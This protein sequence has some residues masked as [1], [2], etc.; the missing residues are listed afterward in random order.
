MALTP[1]ETLPGNNS[2]VFPMKIAQSALIESTFSSTGAVTEDATIALGWKPTDSVTAPLCDETGHYLLTIRK[3]GDAITIWK[4]GAQIAT[5]SY[6][7]VGGATYAQLLQNVLTAIAGSHYGYYSRVVVIEQALDY[8]VF[9]EQSELVTG[10]W[11]PK[12]LGALAPHTLLTFGDSA[13]LGQ[14]GSGNGN[15]WTITGTQ[16]TDTPTNNHATLNPMVG[17]PSTHT[18]YNAPGFSGGNT[19]A[20]ASG[21]GTYNCCLSSMPLPDTGKW[22]W[23]WEIISF[24]DSVVLTLVQHLYGTWIDAFVGNWVWRVNNFTAVYTD[25]DGTTPVSNTSWGTATGDV[26]RVEVD[27]DTK[28]VEFFNNDESQGSF[29]WSM[30]H[31]PLFP[32]VCLESDSNPDNAVRFNSGATG[33]NHTPTVGF[34]ALCAANLEVPVIRSESVADIVLRE[35]TGASAAVSSLEFQPDFV[36]I[37]DRDTARSWGAFDSKRGTEKA[38]FMDLTDIETIKTGSLTAFNTDGYSLGDQTLTNAAGCSFL[39]LCI[40]ENTDQGFEIISYTGNSVVGRQV[41]HSLGRKPGLV[42]IKST[43]NSQKWIAYHH[44]LGA[45][46][47][48]YVNE[49]AAA[50]TATSFWNDTEPTTTTITLGDHYGV[51]YSGAGYIAY[52]F[53]ESDIFKIFGFI[54]NSLADGPFINLG[55]RPKLVLLK[56]TEGSGGSWMLYNAAT[57]PTNPVDTQLLPNGANVETDYAED[58]MFTAN[59]LKLANIKYDSNEDGSLVIGFAILESTNYNNAY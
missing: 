8:A 32:A 29:T 18:G 51:N 59:G 13:N 50:Q 45:T 34:K 10:L 15:H 48:L 4:Q 24:T 3:Q 27:M 26:V 36:L 43:T 22:A 35:G 16:T 21:G 30:A 56:N 9:L 17:Y 54:G 7:T 49:T 37:K 12:S 11:T 38:L 41:A 52:L 46:Q 1:K 14:D 31:G 42:I 19:T 53:A 47:G 25:F 40:A 23:E 33:F 44:G 57:E 2:A 6:A 5:L 28:T 55:G 58:V 20:T 39:D